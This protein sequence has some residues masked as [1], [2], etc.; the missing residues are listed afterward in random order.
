MS[1]G[2]GLAGRRVVVTRA[3]E[4]A[5]SLAELLAERGAEPVV[6]PLVR[7]D[8]EPA[9]RAAL[10]ALDPAG[11]D[12]VIVTSPNAAQRLANRVGA[13]VPGVRA[14]AAVGSATAAVARDAGLR[15]DLV[16]RR[17]SAEGLLDEFA[18]P[19]GTSAL[20][21]QAV[22][23]A[24]TL[25]EGLRDR[26]LLV[27][28]VAPYRAVP[29]TPGAG[30]QLAALAADAVLFASGSAAQAWAEVFGTATPPIVVAIG[31]STAAA[32]TAAG[33][34]VTAV[35]ADHSLVGMVD[36]LERRLRGEG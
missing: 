33:L 35:A 16:P 4:Q 2:R 32:A 17:Q 15:V 5:D 30:Q 29:A 28:A 8:D 6:V 1:E 7:I 27:T 25:V 3:A 22:D 13:G 36:T 26:G 9:G 10:A 14:L 18:A 12:W 24:P 20:V 19:P 23:A 11:F 34:K 31:P 21:V